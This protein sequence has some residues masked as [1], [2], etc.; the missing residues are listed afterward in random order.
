M[1]GNMRLLFGAIAIVSLLTSVGCQHHGNDG[2]GSGSYSSASAGKSGMMHEPATIVALVSDKDQFT[3][4]VTAVGEAHLVDALS[5]RGP[6]TLFAPT[7]AAFSALP[8]GVLG[9]LLKAENRHY[10]QMILKYHVVQGKYDAA[11]VMK[12]KQ[13]QTLNGQMVHFR[14]ENGTVYVNDAR[15]TGVDMDARNG[16]VHQID[17]VLLPSGFDVSD[18]R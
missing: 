12:T 14:V 18:L 7:D 17:K 1:Q 5:A 2:H 13:L 3:T 6:F 9:K 10:L 8:D 15:V 11:R 16:I 4:L